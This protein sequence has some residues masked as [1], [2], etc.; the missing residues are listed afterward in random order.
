M[1]RA[2]SLT[3][4]LRIE[5]LHPGHAA[6]LFPA[7]AD[8]RLYAYIDE[9]RPRSSAALAQRYA[10]LERGAPPG[11]GET[12]LN[13]AIRLRTRRKYIGTLQATVRGD[14][15]AFIAYVLSPMHWRYGYATEAVRWL[16]DHL[17]SEFDVV[18]FGASVDTRNESSWRLLERLQFRRTGSHRAEL[19]GRPSMDYRYHL[20]RA[21]RRGKQRSAD[22]G[23]AASAA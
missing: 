7:L 9:R 10:Q 8:P 21:G 1:T 14:R 16:L 18:E 22:V 4:R 13:W 11:A 23:G 20:V 3:R 5:V 6:P 17:S 15:V 19:H 2:V 12:W